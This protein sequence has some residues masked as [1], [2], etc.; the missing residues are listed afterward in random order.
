MT[1]YDK[2][3]EE[4]TEKHSE[5]I[6]AL[7]ISELKDQIADKDEIITALNHTIDELQSRLPE[8]MKDCTIVFEECEVGHGSL[9]GT[10]WIKTDCPWCEIERLK[11]KCN[12][13]AMIIRR[14][15][16]EQYPDTWFVHTARGEVD[17]NGLPQYID[18]C[19][20]YG[21][22]WSQVYERTKRTIGGMGS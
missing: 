9:R 22:D 2:I 18:V 4:I 1:D 6:K 13:Q 5:S 3:R 19:P 8:E 21:C 20:A 11:N 17:Q 12:Q 10:N 15:Y 7:Y 16:V 14:M